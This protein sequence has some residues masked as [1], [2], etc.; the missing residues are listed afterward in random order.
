MLYYLRAITCKLFNKDSFY[1]I[2][3][4]YCSFMYCY[5]FIR[6]NAYTKY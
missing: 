3:S 1:I 6:L 4:V 2:S 5:H